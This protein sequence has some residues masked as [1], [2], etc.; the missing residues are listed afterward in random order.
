MPRND[1]RPIPLDSV[2][3][4]DARTHAAGQWDGYLTPGDVTLLTSFWKTGKTTLLAG[5]LRHLG[6]GEAFLGRAVRPSA[7]W[8]VSEESPDHWAERV[9]QAP[10][11]PHVH[12]LARPFRGRPTPDDWLALIDAAADARA[13]G[14]LDLF[15]IDPLASFLPGRCESDSASLLDALSPLHRL[16]TA[17]C[18]VLLLHHPR[19]KAAEAGSIARGSGALL[20]LV[21]VAIELTRYS[22]LKSDAHRRLLFAQGRRAGIPA[23]LAY[24][25]DAATGTFTAVADPRERQFTENVQAVLAVLRERSGALTHG[26]ILRH[27]PDE[28]SRPGET[29]LYEWLNRAAA[30]N[31]IR[32]VG[33]GTK[34]SPWRYSLPTASNAFDLPPLPDLPPLGDWHD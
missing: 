4:D 7:V 30:Q 28:T 25:W 8:V 26:E 3:A 34:L 13:A 5:L 16:T 11:G 17:G 27:W 12:L 22:R 15:V 23:R 20:A 29:T 32:R 31:L 19:K 9:R 18:A 24:E 1:L 10:F 21:D 6:T 2:T 33:K 14:R